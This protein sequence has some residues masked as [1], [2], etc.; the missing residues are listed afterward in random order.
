MD[1]SGAKRPV[2]TDSVLKELSEFVGRW[3]QLTDEYDDLEA[4][5]KLVAD[6]IKQIVER[7]IPN[8]LDT[9]GLESVTTLN[10]LKV[11]VK[12]D[13]RASISKDRKYDAHRWLEEH[14]HGDIIKTKLT[15]EFGREELAK[16]RTVAHQLEELSGKPAFIDETVHPQTLGALVRELIR[17]GAECPMETLG[18]SRQRKASIG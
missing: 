7:D 14:G 2:A 6:E 18:V 9:N 17:D 11:V 10:G 4:R 13:I 5:A 1:F 12:E 8:L 16:A 15:T 3:K